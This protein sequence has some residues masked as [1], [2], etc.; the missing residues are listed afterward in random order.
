MIIFW[1]NV[2]FNE[3][4]SG[5]RRQPISV[6]TNY[7]VSQIF[8]PSQNHAVGTRKS[9]TWYNIYIYIYIL[10]AHLS[11]CILTRKPYVPRTCNEY[12]HIVGLYWRG[13][14]RVASYNIY[15]IIQITAC[16]RCSAQYVGV[17]ARIDRTR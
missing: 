2:L 17:G 6:L 16:R 15:F 3:I 7:F 1:R 4:F 8:F 11:I 5:N 13:D 14:D 10:T 12:K 9:F